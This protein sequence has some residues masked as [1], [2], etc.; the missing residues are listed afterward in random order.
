MN[1]FKI[2]TDSNADLPKKYVEEHGIGVVYLTCLFEGKSYGEE[3]VLDPTYFYEKMRTGSMP[4]TSQVNPEEARIFFEEILGETKNI[5]HISFSAELSG[6]YNSVRMAAGELMEERGDCNIIVIDSKSVSLGVGF[7]IHQAVLLR[8][9]GKSC[10][11]AAAWVHGNYS[12]VCNV[13]TVD[14]L[15]HLQRGGRVSKASAIVGT[16]AGIK[17][18]LKVDDSGKLVPYDKIRG[19]KKS[20]NALVDYMKEQIADHMKENQMVFISHG[21]AYEDAQYVA[22]LIKEELGITEFLIDSI[23][24]T[25]G[26]HSGPGTVALFFYG[27]SR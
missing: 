2:T 17:P 9:E 12:N 1:N 23:G 4:T 19:R 7:L 10:R 8:K 3:E 14:D 11:E 27:A 20:L 26:A 16:I 21:D 15:N 24:A 18:L 25:V 22:D 13:F 5:L 6:T